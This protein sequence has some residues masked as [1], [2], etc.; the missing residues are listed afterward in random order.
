MEI[1]VIT[2]PYER[3]RD[4]YGDD[5][6][7]GADVFNLYSYGVGYGFYH[8]PKADGRGYGDGHLYG[9]GWGNGY[10]V[11]SGDRGGGG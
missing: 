4:G 9:D 2:Y 6:G 8:H 11:G 7:Y 10:G 3:C 5:F 1:E